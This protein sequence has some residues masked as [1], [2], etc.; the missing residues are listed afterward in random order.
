MVAAA[1]TALKTVRHLAA[2]KVVAAVAVQTAVVN[3]A[4]V[5]Q[6]SLRGPDNELFS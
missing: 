5:T 2:V 6:N 1:M 3:Q 4:R